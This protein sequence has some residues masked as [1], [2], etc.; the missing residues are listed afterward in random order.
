MRVHV[1]CLGI[2]GHDLDSLIPT[3]E[4]LKELK[5]PQFLHVVTRKGQGYKLA[6]ADPVLYHGV[7]KFD[8]ANGIDSGK[9]GGKLT[10]TQVFGDWLC[11]MARADE[12]L[13]AITPAMRE[14]SGMVRF[15]EEF[16]DRFLFLQLRSN[17]TRP[18]DGEMRAT[19]ADVDVHS[20]LLIVD[21]VFLPMWIILVPV[22]ACC[23]LLVTATE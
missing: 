14:G 18:I 4:N 2:D 16:P 15:S 3:L 11:D 10:Y 1:P 22:S 21:D 19:F 13:V 8:A 23:R 5:G 17:D 9:S 7:S 12:R 20:K 6:E